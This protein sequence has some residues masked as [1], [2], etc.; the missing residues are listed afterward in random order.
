MK[1]SCG[2]T[3]WGAYVP[4]WRISVSEI[5]KVHGQSAETITSNLSIRQKS[6][7]GI[8]E[9]TVTMSMQA[10]LACIDRCKNNEMTL[11]ALYIGSESNPYTVKPSASIVGSMLGIGNEYMAADFQ[12][13]CKAGTTALLCALG[14]TQAG[15]IQRG[16]AIGADTA[17]AKPGDSLEYSA[18][19]GAS[20]ILVSGREASIVATFLG[21]ASYT[22]D[23][24]DF[25]RRPSQ[26]YPQ[27]GERFTGGPAYQQHVVGAGKLLFSKLSMESNDF[28]HVILHQPNG[29]F[30][31]IAGKT[32]GFSEE[33]LQ[34]GLLVEEIGNC[35]AASSMLG[36]IAVLDVAKPGENI[37]LIS[38]GSGAGSDALAFRVTDEILSLQSEKCL[39]DSIQDVDYLSYQ[40]YLQRVHS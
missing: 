22:S 16:M 12:F 2:I 29:K 30:P 28:T 32:L 35:Y 7:P 13:A 39:R 37:L 34:V 19:A 31:R 18:G 23:T 14:Q 3:S 15:M 6:V 36:L 33:Q 10:A 8:D 17:Q 4:R 5:A 9:D 26:Q 27:H 38:Y 1:Y 20:A 40:A 25:W 24:P 21:F 11:G